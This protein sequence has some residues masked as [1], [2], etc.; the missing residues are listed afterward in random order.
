LK[1]LNKLVNYA[2]TLVS[3]LTTTAAAAAATTIA[4]AAVF[5]ANLTGQFSNVTPG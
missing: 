3:C 1:F 4:A 5:V 2:W